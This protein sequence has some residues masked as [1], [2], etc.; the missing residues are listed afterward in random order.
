MDRDKD[1]NKDR[2][3]RDKDKDRVSTEDRGLDRGWMR[4]SI[5]G[6]IG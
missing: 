1:K 5:I 6:R 3:D 4:S 2:M